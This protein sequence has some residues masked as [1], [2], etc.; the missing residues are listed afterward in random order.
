MESQTNRV[1]SKNALA[2]PLLA[3]V[4]AVAALMF[5]WW[6]QGEDSVSERLPGADQPPGADGAA[7]VNPVLAGKLIQGQAQPPNLPGLW[8]QFRGTDRD[9]ISPETT[10]LARSW[11]ATGPRPLWA[12][13]C[14]EGYAG[15]AIREGRVY[16]MDY[17]RDKKQNALRCLSLADGG[18]IWRFAYTMPVKRNHGMTR[19]VPAVTDKYVVAMDPKCHVLCLDAATGELRWGLNLVREFG[20]TIPPWYAGQCPLIDGKS[21]ILAP[22]GHDALLAA[23]DLETGKTFWR[24]PNPHDWKMTHSSVMPMEFAGRRFYVYCGS[25]GVAGISAQ[26][27]TLLWETSAWKIS[28]ATVPSPL[29]LDGGRIFLAGG[30]NAGCLLLQ[31]EDQGGKL[32]PKTVWKLGP[33]VFGAT[34]QTP[35]FHDGHIFGTRPNGQF[36]CLGLD[37]KVLWA[38]PAVDSFGRSPFLLADG[39]LFVMNEDGKLSL[40]EYSTARYNL[41]AQARVLQGGEAWGPMALAG[42]RLLVRDFTHLVCLDVAAASPAR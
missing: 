12:V 34:Q 27:G 5:W 35:L 17:D 18:E 20:S 22:G 40:M 42:G 37:G 11:Q 19:T 6:N 36:V 21:V 38:S 15:V 13:D 39:L 8:P 26:D 4:L 32:T 30:Y 41:L 2:L 7:A 24:A 1:L 31:L 29:V 9:G 33:E 16:L 3:A 25:G 23:V 10:P 28:I 14:G